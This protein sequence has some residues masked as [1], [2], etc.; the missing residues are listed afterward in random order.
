[1]GTKSFYLVAACIVVLAVTIIGYWQYQQIVMRE[2]LVSPSPLVSTS[3]TTDSFTKA[4]FLGLLTNHIDSLE[5]RGIQLAGRYA[6]VGY[7]GALC[8][9]GTIK[10]FEVSN[11]SSPQAVATHEI[12][13]ALVKD[14]YLSGK[15][16]YVALDAGRPARPQVS[17]EIIEV[18]DPTKLITVGTYEMV[19]SVEKIWGY[20]SNQ[21]VISGSFGAKIIDVTDI[22]HPKIVGDYAQELP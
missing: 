6:F 22:T 20:N 19:G 4:Q 2:Q 10:V 15:Y 3:T 18:S 8:C 9:G 7:E 17:F 16:L 11:P 21:I 13:N 1:M 12:P 5:R 14:I